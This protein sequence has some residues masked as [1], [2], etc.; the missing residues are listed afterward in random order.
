[1]IEAMDGFYHQASPGMIQGL[2]PT[3]FKIFQAGTEDPANTPPLTQHDDYVR[4]QFGHPSEWARGGGLV[5]SDVERLMAAS[6]R[7][8]LRDLGG[9]GDWNDLRRR[10]G[11]GG[12]EARCK[13]LDVYIVREQEDPKRVYIDQFSDSGD[14]GRPNPRLAD[15]VE[16]GILVKDRSKFRFEV[17]VEVKTDGKMEGKG[18]GKH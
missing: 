5:A 15:W 16:W 9:L 1:M 13:L 8:L 7:A 6:A 14:R 12:D 2:V 10:G 17:L 3:T 4:L 11:R 18:K